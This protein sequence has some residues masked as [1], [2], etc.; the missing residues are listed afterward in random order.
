MA[1]RVTC[2]SICSFLRDDDDRLE[3]GKMLAHTSAAP[4]ALVSS[5]MDW[6]RGIVSFRRQG[7]QKSGA[8]STKNMAGR[9]RLYQ[10]LEIPSPFCLTS[11]DMWRGF[12]RRRLLSHAGNC[13]CRR[14]RRTNRHSS[15]VCPVQV[16]HKQKRSLSGLVFF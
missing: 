9:G 3:G 4:H 2:M 8:I 14:R 1:S 11:L 5:K 13:C 16:Q 6:G 15:A 12:R 10:V 7:G